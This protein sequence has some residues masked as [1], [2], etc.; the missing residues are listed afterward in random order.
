[1]EF[2]ILGPVDAVEAGKPVPL[3]GAKRRAILALLLLQPN[4]VVPADRLIERLWGEEAPDTARNS[5]QAQV[6]KLRKA[7]QP[8][9][10]SRE[11]LISQPPGYL[12]RLLPEE[13][14]ALR[15]EKLLKEAEDA[16]SNGSLEE[17]YERLE[18]ALSL[19]RGAAL[20]DFRDEPWALAEAQ[21][22]DELRLK[23]QE[24]RLAIALELGRHGDVLAELE[25]L[26]LANPLRE[27][28]QSLLMLAL[29]RA[30]QQAAASDVFHR[31]RER[32]LDELGMEPG[33]EI[34]NL[35]KRIL[36]QDPA[37]QPPETTRTHNLPVQLTEFIGRAREVSEVKGSLGDHRLV[38][39]TGPGGIGKTRIA[40]QVAAQLT[41]AYRDGVWLAELAPVGQGELVVRTIASAVGVREQPGR[42]LAE[43]LSEFI[44]NRELLLVLDNCEHLIETAAGLIDQLLRNAPRLRVLATSRESL[45]IQG[46]LSLPVLP[47]GLP[48]ESDAA[49]LTELTSYE[50]VALFFDRARL[51]L[52]S[53][54]LTEKTA[55]Q[56]V[57]ICKRLDGIPLAMEL[58]AGKLK[59]FGLDQV[60]DRLQDRFRLLTGGSRTSLPRHQTLRAAIDWSYE[61]LSEQE[62]L[63]LCR[64]SVFVGSFTLEAAE[65]VC[66]AAPL[67]RD[68]IAG[69]LEDLASKSILSID[70]REPDVRYRLLETIRAYAGDRLVQSGEAQLVRDRHLAWYLGL[71][72]RASLGLQTSEQD[73]WVQILEADHSNLRAAMAWAAGSG[74]DAALRFVPALSKF[75]TIRGTLAE[76]R[77]VAETALNACHKESTVWARAMT[78]VGI[79]A[80]WQ[81]D[82][83]RGLEYLSRRLSFEGLPDDPDD[84]EDRG[85]AIG[86][87]AVAKAVANGPTPEL[88]V[89][90]RESLDILRKNGRPWTVAS[91]LQN[92]G[93]MEFLLGD[94]GPEPWAKL[95]ES[96]EI[97][98]DL[99]N[100][101]NQVAALCDMARVAL[102]RSDPERAR[103]CW[104]R[105]FELNPPLP[106]LREGAVFEGLAQLALAEHQPE[107]AIALLGAREGLRSISQALF[108]PIDIQESMRAVYEEARA[109]VGDSADRLWREGAALSL[110]EAIAY[111]MSQEQSP[112]L[113]GSVR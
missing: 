78:M 46:E 48:E 80:I 113:V 44:R 21:R 109:A 69:L 42:P 52:P 15:F 104:Q 34:E 24:D 53:F 90:A 6:S 43:T 81:N 55:T 107:R 12:L 31:T 37:L 19:W 75:W 91:M 9:S 66:S 50:G 103:A 111:A 102:G 40:L 77:E 4:R 73:S 58:A 72:E 27:R 32:L 7:L 63:L 68:E 101:F 99:G 10:A 71:A 47:L 45:G 95:E 64:L 59:F 110:A 5:L 100:R 36:R 49:N 62:R 87:V 13:L 88:L 112:S 94:R 61:L 35:F 18:D 14:D 29:Y 67:D 105:V 8:R 22:L 33:P 1:M 30:S 97:Y 79:D 41:G 86:F 76:G 65:S 28:L 92:T 39:L 89:L 25:S 84:L 83:T 106:A 26:A 93:Y 85:M 98:E 70:K 17:S 60:A 56:V 38:T 51:A 20:G 11:Y 23:A 74:G 96:L 57:R 16:H 3:G 108:A 54:R 82:V 2:R